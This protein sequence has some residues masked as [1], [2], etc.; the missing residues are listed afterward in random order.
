MDSE[1]IISLSDV[2][3]EEIE[4]MILTEEESRLK[5][6]I[7]DNLNKD[8]IKDQK[9]K[10]RE[11]KEKR[12]MESLTKKKTTRVKSKALHYIETV[13][14]ESDVKFLAKTPMEAI[15]NSAKFANINPLGKIETLT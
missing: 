8:W 4:K 6:I 7:W 3:D 14:L 1:G 12:K 10:K 9:R 2:D 11:R 15:K 13:F 5:K